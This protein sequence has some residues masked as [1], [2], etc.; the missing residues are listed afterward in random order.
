MS[1]GERP[2]GRRK[3]S[4][5]GDDAARFEPV[6][7]CGSGLSLVADRAHYKIA[8]GDKA[9]ISVQKPSLKCRADTSSAAQWCW[10]CLTNRCSKRQM[11]TTAISSSSVMLVVFPA[12]SNQSLFQASDTDYG[13]NNDVDIVTLTL[14]LHA[15][16]CF[17]PVLT[18]KRACLSMFTRWVSGSPQFVDVGKMARS[19]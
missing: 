15:P 17:Y 3:E 13:E 7:F 19:A 5:R 9:S 12:L 16:R 1:Q 4:S 10:L 18:F 11:P 8:H 6:C 14:Y 2:Q